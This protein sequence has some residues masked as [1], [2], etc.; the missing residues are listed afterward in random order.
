MRS[1]FFSILLLSFSLISSAQNYDAKSNALGG[2]GLLQNNVWSNFTNQAGL[3]EI[4]QFTIGAGT[5]NSFGLKELSTH[6]AVFALP[7][8]GGVFG[9]NVAY[10]GFDLYNESKIGLA[11]AKKLS[12]DFNVGIQVDYLGVYADGA[13][14]N[15]N[16]FT[17]EIGAQ[18]RLMR[19]LTLGAHIFNPIGVKL[20]EDENIPSIFKLGFRYD[21]NEKVAIF[22]EGELESEQ[23]AK[24]KLGLEYKIIKQLQ[25]R[26]GFSANPP[27]N[28]FGLGYTLNNIQL[29]VA[30]K[31]HQLLGYSPQFSVSSAF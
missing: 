30:V 15:H 8:N 17:F 3:S 20:N 12:D 19:E 27:Q 1:Y 24:L 16:N 29:D 7:V 25:L 22:T 31:R 6:T 5:E 14:D 23:N 9:L 2:C 21:A 11:F 4:N 28:T 18:K 10:T 26:A 13:T